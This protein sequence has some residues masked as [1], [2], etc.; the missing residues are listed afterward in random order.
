MMNRIN[1]KIVLAMISVLTVIMVLSTYMI[2]QQRTEV[3]R[4]ELLV[5]AS[6]LARVGAKAMEQFLDDALAS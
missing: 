4:Q 1:I 2:V 6:T 3:L 5:K